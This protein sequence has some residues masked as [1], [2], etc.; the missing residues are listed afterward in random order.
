MSSE[1]E[2]CGEHTLECSGHKK[3][4]RPEKPIDW[5][6]FEELCF[7]QCTSSEVA[8]VLRISVETLYDRVIKN[9]NEH[10]SVV[11]KRYSD[12]G[13][14]SLR[15]NQ[16]NLSKTN[17]AMA[18]WLGKQY[19]G[20]KDISREEVREIGDD[21]IRAVREIQSEPRVQKSSGSIMEITKPLLDKGR[22]GEQNQIPNELGATGT[23]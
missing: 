4:G 8:S 12:G 5:N 23:I 7:I 16:F 20:Q 15:R 11:Y 10:Y 21:I 14:S 1:C 18:I 6:V 3:L 22:S 9:Y 19:L 2:K 17:A 13:K